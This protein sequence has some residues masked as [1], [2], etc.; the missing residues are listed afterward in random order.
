[1]AKAIWEGVIDWL[2]GRKPEEEKAKPLPTEG[3]R[4]EKPELRERV[5]AKPVAKRRKARRKPK[6]RK[7]KRK[8]GK[9]KAKP[10][11]RRVRKTQK[12]PAA[13]ARKKPVAKIEKKVAVR[14]PA[15]KPPKPQKRR[16]KRKPAEK[17]LPALKAVVAEA[18]PKLFKCPVCGEGFRDQQAM[19]KHANQHRTRQFKCPV[20]GEVFLDEKKMLSHANEH[21]TNIERAKREER[22]TSTMEKVVDVISKQTDMSLLSIARKLD[23]TKKDVAEGL[24]EAVTEERFELPAGS[25]VLVEGSVE[26]AKT[27]YCLDILKQKI[28]S[29]EK[30]GVVSFNTEQLAKAL[31]SG[32]NVAKAQASRS[33]NDTSLAVTD[34]LAAGSKTVLVD[35]I[36]RSLPTFSVT[37]VTKFLTLNLDKLKKKNATSLF[38]LE[39]EVADSKTR[40]IMETMF[41]GVIEFQTREVGGRIESL[42]RVKS[43]RG[44]EIST[45]L[46]RYSKAVGVP[47]KPSAGGVV[48]KPAVKT[49]V[50]E[51]A[52]KPPAIVRAE[53]IPTPRPSTGG[54]A[55]AAARP[56]RM[57]SAP[58]EVPA[59]PEAS[60]SSLAS[61]VDKLIEL[62]AAKQQLPE[63]PVENFK[64]AKGELETATESEIDLPAG[65]A[66][67][68]EG[69][70]DSMKYEFCMNTLRKHV[71]RKEAIGT[72]LP[73]DNALPGDLRR[74]VIPARAVTDLNDTSLNISKVLGKDVKIILID[75]LSAAIPS[76][77]L[78]QI[79]RFI[80]LTLAK[81]REKNALTLF[82]LD[83]GAVDEK[84][85]A[86]I[87][88]LFD[89][90]IEFRTREE[91]GEIVS[92]YRVKTMRGGK[93]TGLL[94]YARTPIEVTQ[95][96]VTLEEGFAPSF[97]KRLV[98]LPKKKFQR[99]SR[100]S[101][102]TGLDRMLEL[103]ERDGVVT[104]SKAADSLG[105]SREVI[106]E[107]A[108]V[109][110]EHGM[111]QL[112]YPPIGD[113]Q[114]KKVSK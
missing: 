86:T 98:Q 78:A 6:K 56:I 16:A 36:S 39:S 66:V 50:T 3:L 70:G 68:V 20:C 13:R 45:E 111:V 24:A 93:T 85:K 92:Y 62:M 73:N 19:V 75:A 23:M 76:T 64:K 5:L 32:D 14:K 31:G 51:P 60:T 100:E 74:F 41:D 55:P 67:L 29:G 81:T 4:A 52:V 114:V 99:H 12:K 108:G 44:E 89:G 69:P 109:L 72:C 77:T 106:E 95:K 54:V 17:K 40:S 59:G 107:W 83:S 103:V 33:L 87:E 91:A 65:A 15:A 43:F 48:A 105:V 90:V 102:V 2:F 94:R 63:K 61:T 42:Y 7:A 46:R 25:S 18:V 97:L 58:Q 80:T 112:Y 30:V 38:L 28:G 53:A 1:M 9:K 71:N 22:L 84:T 113:L 27:E 8:P 37:E 11:K 10:R 101:L 47:V 26:S 57:K 34:V 49:G 96:I 82:V 104:I 35:V 21:K 110:E 79:T 88:M